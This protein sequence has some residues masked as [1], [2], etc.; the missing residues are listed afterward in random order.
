MLSILNEQVRQI[1]AE[2]E[3]QWR[4]MIQVEVTLLWVQI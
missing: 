2:G 1:A 4:M 3:E